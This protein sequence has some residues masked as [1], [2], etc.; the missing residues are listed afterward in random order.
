[1]DPTRPINFKPI[2]STFASLRDNRFRDI[3]IIGFV[4]ITAFSMMNVS[5][6]F[7]WEQKYGLDVDHVGLM[8]SLVGVMSAVSQGALV[9]VFQKWWG[10]RRM[11]IYGCVLVGLGLA[12][13]PFV[14]QVYFVA[15]SLIPIILLHRQRLPE[16]EPGRHPEPRRNT[17][18]W[19]R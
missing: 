8:F 15:F 5:I 7:L 13:I 6:A 14:P 16:P 1:M 10:E 3:F 9:G 18:N 12:A 17:M 4:Y 11:M 19:G 2:A